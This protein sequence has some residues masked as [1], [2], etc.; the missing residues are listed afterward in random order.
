MDDTQDD[1]LNDL[2]MLDADERL[3]IF[4]LFCADCGIYLGTNEVCYHWND[5]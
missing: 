2:M 5:E 1:I 3:E 4:N